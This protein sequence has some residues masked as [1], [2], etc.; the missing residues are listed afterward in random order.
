MTAAELSDGSGIPEDVVV[1]KFGLREKHIAAAGRARQRHGRTVA[2]QL[3]A[4]QLRP[5]DDRRG[6]LL[7][8]T[9]KDYPIWQAAP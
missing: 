8:L 1:E 7:R 5:G 9:W 4:E 2:E 3:L 6:P